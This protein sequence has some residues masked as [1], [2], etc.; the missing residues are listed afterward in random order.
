MTTEQLQDELLEVDISHTLSG[1]RFGTLMYG[2]DE[3]GTFVINE[4]LL[5]VFPG[6]L[7]CVM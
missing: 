1:A 4:H 3:D 2:I 7:M 5:G 6:T